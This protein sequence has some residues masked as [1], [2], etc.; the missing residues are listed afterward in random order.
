MQATS[1][2]PHSVDSIRGSEDA[3]PA[4]PH[5][6]ECDGDP[7]WSAHAALL[8]DAAMENGFIPAHVV[9]SRAYT[10]T[11]VPVFPTPDRTA[12]CSVTL[13]TPNIA[14]SFLER[15]PSEAKIYE[16]VADSRVPNFRG[17]QIPVPHQLNMEAWDGYAHLLD[18]TSLIPMLRYGFPAGYEAHQPPTV[19]LANHSSATK[20]PTHIDKYLATEL[21]HEALMG[22]FSELPFKQWTRTNP[23]M[24]RSKKDS[25]DMRV[26][27]DLSFPEG[28]SV[29]AAIPSG[30]LDGGAFKLRLPTP[31][32]L[33]AKIA[34]LGKGCQLHKIDLSRA[35]RQLR[36]DPLEWPL[37]G[38]QWGDQTYLDTAI[39]FGLRH[40]ASACQRTSEAVVAIAEA[41]I[42]AWALPYIDDT[43]GAAPAEWALVHYQGVR[44][45]MSELGLVAAEHKCEP[46]TTRLDWVG[47][48][49]DTMEM[50]M[51]IAQGKIDEATQLCLQFLQKTEVD[52]KYMQRFLGKILHAT[53]CTEPARRF[54]SR[55]QAHSG[56][57]WGSLGCALVG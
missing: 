48:T 1:V 54:T 46:L 37:L 42:D 31:D 8:L 3:S 11:P 18:D 30:S 22:P 13:I 53:R 52:L 39:P 36:S 44:R 10:S 32:M 6:V 51:F 14:K 43:V 17:V 20:H 5:F 40:G 35:Y 57:R 33:A 27:L 38:I 19:G 28:S 25:D 45:L 56:D 55:L 7:Q 41:I 16:A 4:A 15:Y 23:L 26:I 9:N 47:V 29:N 2:G 50:C 34:E 21:R 12:F 24:T 49:F